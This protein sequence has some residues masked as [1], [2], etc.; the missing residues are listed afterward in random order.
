M[1]WGILKRLEPTR[2][3]GEADQREAAE[4]KTHGALEIFCDDP[5]PDAKWQWRFAAKRLAKPF[6]WDARYHVP[7]IAGQQGHADAV[8]LPL[9]MWY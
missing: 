9:R 4:W 7:E 6:A 8:D 3:Q 2:R 5:P 1:H